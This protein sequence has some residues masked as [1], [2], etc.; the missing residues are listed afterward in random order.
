MAN[1]QFAVRVFYEDT[2][3]G[4]VVYYANYLKFFERARTEW[5]RS[6]GFEQQKLAQEQS[7]FFVVRKVETDYLASARLDDL[8]SVSV[9][10]E[11]LGRVAVEF[12]QEIHCGGVLLTRCRTKVACV[13]GEHFKP[14][15][16]PEPVRMAM[17]NT[18]TG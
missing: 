15:A 14:C 9:H 16:L 17:Q 8:L 18:L 3:A 1:F 11:K 10:I 6:L 5:L 12:A 7:I 4:G 13:S 2:D